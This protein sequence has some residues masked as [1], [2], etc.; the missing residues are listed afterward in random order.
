MLF[1]PHMV[2][3]LNFAQL[4]GR[5]LYCSLSMCPGNPNKWTPGLIM[6]VAAG[7]AA[8]F[9]ARV[10]M[11]FNF[12]NI[13]INTSCL[14]VIYGLMWSTTSGLLPFLPLSKNIPRGL[15]I[16]NPV[17]A[18]GT[19]VFNTLAGVLY[20]RH[21]TDGN[22]CYGEE[23]YHTSD[24]IMVGLSGVLFVVAG[25]RMLLG[26]PNPDGRWPEDVSD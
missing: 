26:V 2:C 11:E 20:E 12:E 21:T 13:L 9:G 14:G 15:T 18:V 6:V 16:T 23:C 4:A 5:L 19:V 7:Y 17:G 25:L 8:C 1:L 3:S 22:D 24:L 10:Y